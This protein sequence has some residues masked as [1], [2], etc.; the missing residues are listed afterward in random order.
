MKNERKLAKARK[1]RKD[2]EKKRNVKNN[3]WP[4]ATNK[5]K[6]LSAGDGILPSSKKNKLGKKEVT[7]R[8]TADRNAIRTASDK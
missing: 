1:R 5:H 8:K 6:P 4:V 2:F 3:N 7:R